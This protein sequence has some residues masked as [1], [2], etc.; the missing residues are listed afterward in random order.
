MIGKKT[1]AASNNYRI[2]E[3]KSP[4]NSRQEV[5]SSKP[6]PKNNENSNNGGEMGSKKIITNNPPLYQKNVISMKL[7]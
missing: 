7:D 1:D 3:R 4:Y 5:S 6:D 2:Q